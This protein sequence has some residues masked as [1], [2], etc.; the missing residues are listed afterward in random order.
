MSFHS[1]QKL[2]NQK[3][4][5]CVTVSH[6]PSSELCLTG[7]RLPF[8]RTTTYTVYADYGRSKCYSPEDSC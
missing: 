6:L 5:L 7:A 3:I 1:S 8:G 2:V 4:L